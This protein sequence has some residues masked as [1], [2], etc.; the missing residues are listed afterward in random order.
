[1]LLNKMTKMGVVFEPLVMFFDGESLIPAD[2]SLNSLTG[3]LQEATELKS[4][5]KRGQKRNLSTSTEGRGNPRLSTEQSL[6]FAHGSGHLMG[7]LY[8]MRVVVG[9]R[10]LAS[11]GFSGHGNSS[12]REQESPGELAVK[13]NTTTTGK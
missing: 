6:S 7:S 11:I 3:S 1:M 12:H 8:R 10:F 5:D 2:K 13:A 9:R 4:P